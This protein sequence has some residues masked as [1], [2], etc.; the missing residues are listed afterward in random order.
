MTSV[1]GDVPIGSY[2]SYQLKH[3]DKVN[4]NFQFQGPRL[5]KDEVQCKDNCLQFLDIPILSKRVSL[6][7]DYGDELRK[8]F[9]NKHI[10]IDGISDSIELKKIT[11]KQSESKEWHQSTKFRLT[12][13]SFGTIFNRVKPVSGPMLYSIFES[14]D[15]SKVKSINHG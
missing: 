15:L 9:W 3:F 2:L 5:N 14:K 11:V 7:Y 4:F 10:S 1:F 12:S 13:S 6:I 8:A